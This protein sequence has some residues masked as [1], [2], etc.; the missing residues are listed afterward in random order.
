MLKTEF[1][2]ESQQRSG[3]VCDGLRLRST[4]PTAL[5]RA[6]HRCGDDDVT[7]C[8][9]PV[10]NALWRGQPLPDTA[11]EVLDVPLQLLEREAKRKQLLELFD[12]QRREVASMR[13]GVRV[14]F[15]SV[16]H[17]SS[18]KSPRRS[19]PRVA[20]VEGTASEGRSRPSAVN[21]L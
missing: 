8:G 6:V 15:F 16:M 4:R 2:Q 17:A 1:R 21:L 13:I 10:T 3:M 14:E 19:A 9:S 20:L 5:V 7:S 18:G 12:R 11:V